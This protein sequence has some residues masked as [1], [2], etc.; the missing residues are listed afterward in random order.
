MIQ[1][2][3]NPLQVVQRLEGLSPIKITLNGIVLYN[4]YDSNVEIEPGVFGEI[5]SP[6]AM[7]PKRLWQIENYV[8]TSVNIKI[9][10]HHHSIVEMKGRYEE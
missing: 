5:Q 8:V 7:L 10:Q 1:S 2:E 9:V 4:D 3:L 6:T